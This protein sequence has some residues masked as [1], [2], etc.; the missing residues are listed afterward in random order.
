MHIIFLSLHLPLLMA[1]PPCRPSLDKL[2]TSASFPISP[3][4]SLVYYKADQSK[5][6]FCFPSQSNEK[7][8]SFAEDQG[9]QFTWKI[10]TSNTE[11]ILIFVH[12]SEV[13]FRPPL[14]RGSLCC[15]GRDT[16][17]I[18]HQNPLFMMLPLLISIWPPGHP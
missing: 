2:L 14:T 6:D 13:P 12:L 17:L 11:K 15:K 8:V 16:R 5:P 4:G 1:S 18:S 9:D 10:L 7:W 3:F